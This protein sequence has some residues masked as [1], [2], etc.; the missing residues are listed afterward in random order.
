M[1]QYKILNLATGRC[2]NGVM[3][4][5]HQ[6]YNLPDIIFENIDAAEQVLELLIMSREV[7]RMPVL[8]PEHLEIIEIEDNV[9]N[10]I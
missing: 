2:Y 10:S 9:E 3:S 5:D 8:R 1:T 6:E 4:S 7:L